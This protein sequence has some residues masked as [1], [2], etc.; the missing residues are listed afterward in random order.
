MP[1]LCLLGDSIFDNTS[2]TGGKPAVITQVRQELPSH[3]RAS[4]LAVDGA[5]TA[6]IDT[7][8]RRLPGDASHLVLS[9]GGNNA[10]Q[11][12][13]VL[14]APVRSTAEA[15]TRLSRVIEEFEA[16]Y[17]KAVATC[18]RPDLPLVVCS[19]Y[20]GSFPDREY[21]RQVTVALALFND[22]IIRTAAE[23]RLTTIE[24]RQICNKPEDFANPIEPSSIGGQKIARAIAQVVS[25]PAAAGH[26]ARI[27]GSGLT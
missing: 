10:L 16:A 19:I 7:Q 5:T 26:G 1:H 14:N 12:A 15:L 18:L 3:W 4:L 24:L 2:Y 27:V 13:G 11:Q 25:G 8:T 17:R 22:V 6:S 9:V 23:N 21:Q 20:N